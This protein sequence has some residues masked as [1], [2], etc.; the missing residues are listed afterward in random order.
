MRARL[1][2]KSIEERIEDILV[3]NAASFWI[4]EALRSAVERDCVDAAT[5][6]KVLAKLLCDRQDAILGLPY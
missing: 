3:D 6:A 2:D 1:S 5:D 4:K